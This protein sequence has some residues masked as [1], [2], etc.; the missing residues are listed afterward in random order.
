MASTESAQDPPKEEVSRDAAFAETKSSDVPGISGT[1]DTPG[2]AK[3]LAE[4]SRD[5][6]PSSS[7]ASGLSF[8]RGGTHGSPSVSSSNAP[9]LSMPH[10]K[11]FSHVNINK[12]FLEKTSSASTPP[13]ASSA[14]PVPRATNATQKPASQ[15]TTPHPRLVTAKLT[16]TPQPSSAGWSRPPSAV[17]STAPTPLPT[18]GSR[19]TTGPTTTS[20]VAPVPPPGGKVIHPLLRSNQDV[21][22][23]KR[24]LSSKP[25]W[26]N[27]RG[28][29]SSASGPDGVESEFPT[30]AEVA[31][32]RTK[33]PIDNKDSQDSTTA[34][35]QAS[36][37]AE[38]TFR[39]VHLDPNAHHWD[40]MEEDD[41][42][43]LD[44]VIE[45][46]DG[47]QYTVQPTGATRPTTPPRGHSSL[48]PL[49]TD[50]PSSQGVT[51]QPVS[52]EERFADDFDRSWPRSHPGVIRVPSSSRDHRSNGSVVSPSST[53]A[54][55][56]QDASR[57]L[58][59]E[60]SNRLEPYS[61]ARHSPQGPPSHPT[62]RGSRSEHPILP[63][64]IRR[65][66]P[67]HTQPQGVQLL[68]K[69]QNGAPHSD[70]SRTPGDH[71]L[72]PDNSRFRDRPPRRDLPWQTDGSSTHD[73]S[74]PGSFGS[75][76]SG[77]P[78]RDI[79]SDDR[80]RSTM[81]PPPLP[82][83]DDHRRQ[84][85]P[86]FSA[87]GARHVPP[88]R[89]ESELSLRSPLP[90][91]TS[92][93]LPAEPPSPSAS[94]QVAR[95]PVVPSPLLPVADEE[96]VRKAA[97]HSAAERA[98]LR[99]QQEE[100]ERQK[101][102]ERAKKKAQEI[103]ERMKSL[104]EQAQEREKEEA[105][106]RKTEVQVLGIIEEAVSSASL[107]GKNSDGDSGAQRHHPPMGRTPSSTGTSRTFPPR[108]TSLNAPAA[109][110]SPSSDGDTW[111]R[112][113]P[114]PPVQPPVPQPQAPAPPVM[115]PSVL[116]HTDLGVKEGEDVDVVD[117]AD[118]GKLVESQT[119]P[120]P[121]TTNHHVRPPRAVAADFFEPP[122]S[123]RPPPPSSK[124]DEGPWRRRPSLGQVSASLPE[125]PALPP[126]DDTQSPVDSPHRPG[127]RRPSVTYAPGE[128][129]HRRVS[130]QF[131]NG[132]VKVPLGQHYREAPMA[133]LDDTMARIK[134]ALDGARTHPS[135]EAPKEALKPAKWLPPAL[136]Q[137]SAQ[138]LPQP[139][140]VFDVTVTQPPKSPKPAW[141]AFIVKAPPV[142]R[143][144][145][146][147][148]KTGLVW[149][150]GQRFMRLEP[151]TWDQLNR[152]DI[153]PKYSQG[154]PKYFVSIP[155][156]PPTP[157]SPVVNLPTTPPRLR[158]ANTKE[159]TG[160]SWRKAP[161]SPSASEPV[162][163]SG[164]TFVEDQPQRDRTSMGQFAASSEAQGGSKLGLE[165]LPP[166]AVPSVLEV[167]P[168][169]SKVEKHTPVNSVATPTQS[170]T[171]LWSKSP[172]AFALKES[173]SRAPDPEHLKAV[174]STTPEKAQNQPINS[175]KSIAD[176]LTGVPFIIQ[177][178][179]TGEGATPPPP[180]SGPWTRMSAYEVTR[181]FQQRP[182]APSVGASALTVSNTNGSAPRPPEF[183]FS[184]PPM[185]P[186]VR[187]MYPGYSP[188]SSPIPRPMVINGAAPPYPHAQ[189]VWVP[190]IPGPGPP[191]PQSAG[192]MRSPY[193]TQLMPY[194]S[195]GGAMPMYA[196]HMPG[197]QN[198]AHPPPQ[199][200]VQGRPPGMPLPAMPSIY[201]GSPVLVPTPPVMAPGQYPG[202][203]NRAPPMRSPYEQNTPQLPPPHMAPQM[204]LGQP[205]ANGFHP[206]PMPSNYA[207]RSPW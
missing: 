23:A 14:S 80:R 74:R 146:P 203:V 28:N 11:K 113:Q 202:Q 51:D 101:A 112:K 111:R 82:L 150:R 109:A 119:S 35:K 22:S 52:K 115:S 201:A 141:N 71:S 84:L 13:H 138:D 75:H 116:A 10:P 87:P 67:P 198:H 125:K 41:D 140:E 185:G 61:Q 128:E 56:P 96:E 164:D 58:F 151:C 127:A 195:A 184:P 152:R 77:R 32:G 89:Q 186:N 6:S 59:N 190:A 43:F 97:M 154:Q 78:T 149:P 39:G 176:D 145:A 193:P 72:S 25:V 73:S 76:P 147:P 50:A 157:S 17:S 158:T 166:P 121:L 91:F 180:G 194:P 66:A 206:P 170:Q 120:E 53:S 7:V 118:L 104:D 205:P 92:V 47:R 153:T 122:A 124:A 163:P 102:Q 62:R 200:G 182:T 177:D 60:R 181:A 183:S 88:P 139:T 44:G 19:L 57:V 160:P 8:S 34:Q 20:G 70:I 133:A 40:E 199:N 79:S 100:E 143:P 178:V 168:A 136:R 45:F 2:A 38:D 192:L 5:P 174:W 187:S 161:T 31:Q 42:N 33:K 18:Q 188:M 94:T 129:H 179:K 110:P 1:G 137:K 123:Q 117:F 9:P 16:A 12:K 207:G 48:P 142:T 54:Q 29:G 4:R 3:G 135:A 189:P 63:S 197:M 108:R 26:G 95:S 37:T 172:R 159:T 167:S 27:T 15:T 134:G 69:T 103:E 155:R 191:L 49:Q 64:E 132:T 165:M 90:S 106:K 130:G 196:S 24:D 65:D 148:L 204:R 162:A 93:P 173:P 171:S 86:H 175:L 114:L 68:Q 46:G 169:D 144:V 126:G 107:S 98:R 131:Q 55:S 83:G 30:A 156:R 21:L 99:R 85:P 105:E 81:G 36:V